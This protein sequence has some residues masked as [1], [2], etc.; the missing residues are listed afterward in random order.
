MSDAPIAPK[1]PHTMEVHGDVRVDPW[2]WMRDDDR[3]DAEILAHL[4][5]EN[6]HTDE[7]LAPVMA[8]KDEL[9]AEMRGR[10]KEDDSSVPQIRDGAWRY[11]RFEEGSEYAIHC[12]R[13]AT[14][15]APEEV[16][17]DENERAEGHSFYSL[18]GLAVSRDGKTVAFAE[19][20]LSRR[21][22]D[23]RFRSLADDTEHDEVIEQT[24]GGVVWAGDHR[25]VFYVRQEDTTLRD[26]QVWRHVLGTSAADDVL[27]FEEPDPEYHVGVWLTRSREFVAIGSFQTESSE[28][29]TI[30]AEQPDEEPV[31]FLPRLV[32]HEYSIDHHGGRFFVRSDLDSPNHRLLATP[33]RANTTVDGF[34]EIVAHDDEVYVS[35]FALFDDA[36][37]V[38][39]RRNAVLGV[40]VIPWANPSAGY[41]IEFDEDVYTA[42][43]SAPGDA[44]GDLVR[45]V[46]TSLTTPAR[47]YD[48]SFTDRS[49]D[50]RKE[51]PVLGDF[52]RDA[53]V[54]ERITVTARDGVDVPV[55]LVHR[56]DLDRTVPQP[57]HL[58]GYGSYGITMDPSFS[59]ARLAL[60]DR[61]FVFAIAHVRGGQELGRRWY[62]D[63]K[64]LHKRNTFTDFIDVGQH[65]VDTRVTSPAQLIA[66]GGS[67]GGLLMGA[68]L[69]MRPDLFGA[70]VA[71]VAFVDVVTTM[72][73]ESIPLT[74]FE[75]DEWGNPNLPEFY[76]YMLSYSPY[77]NIEAVDH[78]PVFALAGLHDS[79]VQYWEPAK[80]VA[81]LRDTSTSDA[82]VLLRM[83]MDAGHGGASGRFARLEEVALEYAFM[84]GVID[85]EF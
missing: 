47:V 18:G 31:V 6:A 67:A 41:D 42:G 53:Y 73:D 71:Q 26:Y 75:Y 66:S 5:A 43:I 84:L 65:L 30:A 69:N 36:L 38:E 1:R 10:I 64:L 2:Y 32:G 45:L 77:D 28:I 22:Y 74:T 76:E 51:Q 39:E 78:P 33:E 16:L 82:P 83:N 79:Q 72:L 48:F 55:S 70:I 20:T 11:S 14:M 13:V 8:L 29:R 7:V 35:D 9:F 25:T 57:L 24:S 60:L 59:S 61:G 15:D 80:W 17:L 62:D 12:R 81:K 85:G 68:V 58:Y 40:R 27:V 50:L 3:E 56:R 46:Y 19:D 52:D 44:D 54:A 34:D 23:L 4:H 37:V 49:L 21:I 63:G